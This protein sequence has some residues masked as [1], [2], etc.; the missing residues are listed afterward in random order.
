MR[1]GL[2]GNPNA[3]EKLL[4][5]FLNDSDKMVRM[6]LAENPSASDEILHALLDDSDANVAKAAKVHL[7]RRL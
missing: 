1:D 4:K 7:E 2:S 6:R 3:S 5:I